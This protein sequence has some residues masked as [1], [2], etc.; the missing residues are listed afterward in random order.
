MH[1]PFWTTPE[2]DKAKPILIYGYGH[3]CLVFLRAFLA[4]GL[5]VEAIFDINPQY[6]NTFINGIPVL[7]PERISNFNTECN[8]FI[9]LVQY[10]YTLT[11]MFKERGF[12]HF[13]YDF[14]PE[15]PYL[16]N[17]LEKKDEHAALIA[18]NKDKI[19]HVRQLLADDAS[20]EV[21]EAALDAYGHGNWERFEATAKDYHTYHPTGNFFTFSEEEVFIDC[22]AYDGDSSLDFI[23]QMKHKYKYIYAFEP[24]ELECELMR[25][26]FERRDDKDKIEIHKLAIADKEGMLFFH[27]DEGESIDSALSEEGEI[28]VQAT[29]LDAFFAPGKKRHQPTFIKMDIEG[30]EVEALE[31]AKSIIS[32]CLPKLAISAYHRLEHYWEVPLKIS[33]IAD[34]QH[35]EMCYRHYRS[36]FD[37]VL[38]ARPKK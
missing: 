6:H 9:S 13:Y 38:F 22:G 29:S 4:A 34:G 35:Y 18:K 28:K 36:C 5:K 17:Q 23:D 14:A 7:S 1:T 16:L 30:A 3:H 20:K 33:E 32:K 27:V 2:F 24:L 21:F 37:T 10:K 25:R 19:T 12:K 26:I 8:V 15:M 11:K 31:G